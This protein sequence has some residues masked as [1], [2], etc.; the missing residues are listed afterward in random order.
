MPN[1]L[2]MTNSSLRKFFPPVHPQ[3]IIDFSKK[4]LDRNQNEMKQMTLL[5]FLK[6]L[7]THGT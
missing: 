2:E 7:E 4:L 5:K 6:I 1:L 3:S